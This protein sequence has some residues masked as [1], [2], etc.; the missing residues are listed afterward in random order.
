MLKSN[1]VLET[2]KTPTTKTTTK[3]A[4][5]KSPIK[6]A[7]KKVVKKVVKKSESVI[8]K[9][10][11][12]TNWKLQTRSLSALVRYAKNEGK[13]DLQ[14]LIDAT[15]KTKKTSVTIGQIANI[16]NIVAMASERELYKNAS[17]DKT[18]F[19]KGE[20]KELFSFWLVILTVGRMAKK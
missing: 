15:N 13:Q 19:V 16:K 3:K 7:V 5:K 18:K 11:V 4:V 8:L 6:K 17:E 10:S 20:K 1:S 12:N 2:I 14:K 9:T